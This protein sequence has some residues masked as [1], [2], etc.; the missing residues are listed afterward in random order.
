MVSLTPRYW[1]SAPGQRD[2]HA[3]G[4]H[5]GERHRELHH[6]RRRAGQQM[7]GHRGRQSAQHQRAFAADDHQPGLGGQRDAQRGEDQ[8]RGARQRVLPGERARETAL[9]D[10]RIDFERILAKY[11]DEQPEQD[12]RRQQRTG[13]DRN[14]FSAA[15]AWP[16]RGR[17]RAVRHRRLLLDFAD[18]AFDQVVH[19]L[20]HGSV[21]LCAVP[22][23]ITVLPVLSLSGPL[24]MT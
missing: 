5:A 22:A 16:K 17:S 1:R 21:C 15:A 13:R 9:V 4:H 7:P 24:K 2:P 3:A 8:R 11:G 18:D 6:E 12:H 20:E 23:A 10:E 19:L 14:R